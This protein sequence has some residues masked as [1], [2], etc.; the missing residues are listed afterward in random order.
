MQGLQIGV[1]KGSCALVALLGILGESLEHDAFDDG[2]DGIIEL[3][4]RGGGA[5][6]CFKVMPTGVSALKGTRPVSI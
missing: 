5:W 1:G 4:W 3:A 6:I 2:G